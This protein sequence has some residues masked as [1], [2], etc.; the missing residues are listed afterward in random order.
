M[1]TAIYLFVRPF[2]QP[3]KQQMFVEGLAYLR[4]G[5]TDQGDGGHKDKSLAH[6][7]SSEATGKRNG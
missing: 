4:H 1:G 7:G 6:Q 5:P 3:I 2:T